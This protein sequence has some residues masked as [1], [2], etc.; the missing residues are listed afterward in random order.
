[1][2]RINL[3]VRVALVLVVIALFFLVQAYLSDVYSSSTVGPRLL[4]MVLA[5]LG[6]ALGLIYGL[7]ALFSRPSLEPTPNPEA[8]TN[9][10]LPTKLVLLLGIGFLYVLLFEML[11]YALSTGGVLAAVL[12]VFGNRGFLR[13]PAISIVGTAI[14]YFVFVQQM[15]VYDPQGWLF[16]VL[17]VG[18]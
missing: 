6:A 9:G 13:I 17:D 10:T 8:P 12:V 18:K 2:S 3:E 7:I 5:G 14:Y 1:M 16:D 15:G 4:P 11:G